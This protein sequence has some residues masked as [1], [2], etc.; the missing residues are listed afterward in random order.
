MRRLYGFTEAEGWPDDD[1]DMVMEL[2]D[3]D[4]SDCGCGDTHT[5][6]VG[7]TDQ[8]FAVNARGWRGLPLAPRDSIFDKDD[9]V[10]RIAAWAGVNAQGADVSKLQRAFM[11]YNPQLPPADPTSYWLPIGD[12]INGKLTVIYHAIY[13]AAAL[14]SG[15]HGGLPNIPDPD[16]AQLRNVISDVYQTMAT[17]FND[18][19]I[20]APWDRSAQEGV[21]LSMDAPYSLSEEGYPLTP[22]AAWF[23]DPCL[24]GRTPLTV[25]A[26][27]RVYGH[28]A[29]WGECHRD[30]AM[31][32]CVLAPRSR[33][34]YA[35]FHLGNV[36]TAEGE[37]VKVGKI[38]MDTRHADIRL[39]YSAAVTH[40]DDTGAE[41]AVVRAGEDEHGIWFSGAIV[42]EATPRK[43]AKLRRSPLSVTGAGS[44]GRQARWS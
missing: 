28:L 5:V 26:A 3:D 30:V 24:P 25:T 32:E 16:K 15:A 1:L 9:A 38:V 17:E 35:P 18:S 27:G 29:L 13:A 11:Y 23:E 39:G 34:Q 12:I 22:P 44:P 31:R 14:L 2:L 19:S 43:V 7:E 6:G 42:P 33:Q 36:L 41:I 21:Q 8:T 10:K 40:Y 20:R 4:D 37:L